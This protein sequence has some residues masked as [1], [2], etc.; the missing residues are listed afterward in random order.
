MRKLYTF[1]ATCAF[2]TFVSPSFAQHQAFNLIG[3]NYIESDASTLSTADFTLEFW[4][5]VD[6]AAIDGLPHQFVSVGDVNGNGFYI[7]YDAT[8]TML[9]GDFWLQNL[10][11]TG[12]Q[13]PT[14]R[15]THVAISVNSSTLDATLYLNGSVVASGWVTYNAGAPFR[16]GAMVT[17]PT[18]PQFAK[19]K[20]DDMKSWSAMRSPFTI[21]RDMFTDPN[22]SDPT[23]LAWYK[24][25]D[26]G[27]HLL[28]NSITSSTTNI[29]KIKGDG[30]LDGDPVPANYWTWSPISDSSNALLFDGSANSQVIIP[31]SA[32]YD[33]ILNGVSAT[34]GTIEFNFNATTL[35]TAPT[36]STV[37]S[38]FGQYGILMNTTQIAID[39]GTAT[40]LVYSLQPGDLPNDVVPTGEWHQMAFV[41]DPTNTVTHIYY[42]GMFFADI[43]GTMGTPQTNTLGAPLPVTLGITK[44][45]VNGD[46]QPFNGAIDEVRLWNSPLDALTIFSNYDKTLSGTEPGLISQFTFDQGIATSDNTGMITAFDQVA[47]NNGTLQNFAL[48][49]STSNFVKHA[50][51]VIPVPLPVTLTKFNA[52]RNGVQGYLQWQTAQEE[53]SKE[54]VIERSS[55]GKTFTAIGTV[56]AA[57]K[58]SQP[59]DYNFTDLT[60][61]NGPNYYRLR[62][63]DLDSKYTYSMVRV[64]NFGESSRVTW[65]KTGHLTAQIVYLRGNNESYSLCD[66][67]GHILRQGQLSGGKA[68]VSNLPAGVYIV[69]VLT[70]TGDALTTKLFLY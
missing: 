68:N 7:G 48:T 3:S 21:R 63:A 57:G 29:G 11:T 49:G 13:M 2:V 25:N 55:D 69:R 30:G 8:G 32:A 59:V 38:K 39:N 37:L 17:T 28:D 70:R 35:P 47:A 22:P 16:I 66:I 20:I 15:W 24:M 42:D 9:A 14:N 52:F 19:A 12:V 40:P 18:D 54:F 10:I 41:N 27:T 46:K 31:D 53:N 33:N 51:T 60:P 43:P 62:E 67:G 4:V 56:S 44:D 64:L 1:L 45:P 58:S 65:F 6:A 50:L 23:L 5:Y 26:N 36:F 61:I 34:G